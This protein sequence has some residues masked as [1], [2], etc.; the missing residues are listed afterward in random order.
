M[1]YNGIICEANKP[2]RVQRV[3][4]HTKRQMT[5]EDYDAA[6]TRLY[7]QAD[8]IHFQADQLGDYSQSMY[9]E[10]DAIDAAIALCERRKD[11]APA[12]AAWQ[13]VA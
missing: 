7:S 10:L 6:I 11:S 13:T 9:N 4:R 12:R 2:A 3:Q 5:V 8:N 1:K